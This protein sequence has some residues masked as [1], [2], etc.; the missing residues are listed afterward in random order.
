MAVARK[1][2]EEQ[3]ADAMAILREK[4]KILTENKKQIEQLT[5]EQDSA[6]T[7]RTPYMM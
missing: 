6:R 7:V 5:Q 3:L 2:T 4:N 1:T